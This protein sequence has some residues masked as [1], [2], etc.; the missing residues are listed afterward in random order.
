MNSH[1]NFKTFLVL[2]PKKFQISVIDEINYE[3]IYKQEKIFENYLNK[4]DLNFLDT[5][6]E[7]NIFKIEKILN[8]FIKNINLVIDYDDFFSLKISIKKNYNYELIEQNKLTLLLN[9]ARDLCKDTFKENKIIHMIIENYNIDNV[10]YDNLPQNLKCNHISLD[11]NFICLPN[12]F[13]KNLEKNINKYQISLNRI[14]SVN[15]INN[16]F[17]NKNL[18][19]IK[20]SQLVIDGHNQNEVE[21]VNKKTR[22]NGFFERFFHFFN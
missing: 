14:V 16:L 11:I 6:L 13:V 7:K 19:L 10:N 3:Q 9:E 2:S 22:I 15:Y 1:S 18:D 8:K 5:F 21:L 4:F 20:M 12:A 17:L